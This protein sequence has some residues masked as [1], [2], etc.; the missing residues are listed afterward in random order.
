VR[1][2]SS[3]WKEAN[4]GFAINRFGY[5]ISTPTPLVG[6]GIVE[7]EGFALHSTVHNV[8]SAF[9]WFTCIKFHNVT[10]LI[11][12]HTA[13]GIEFLVVKPRIE[14]VRHLSHGYRSHEPGLRIKD[15]PNRIG[16]HFKV[17]TGHLI[18]FSIYYGMDCKGFGGFGNH[19]RNT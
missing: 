14:L 18:S 8:D 11:I 2:R 5:L 19:G 7:S 3:P 15:A 4:R 17:L 1:Y 12:Y 9:L 6:F 10:F 16:Q 13:S